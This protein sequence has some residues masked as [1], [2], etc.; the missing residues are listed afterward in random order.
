MKKYLVWSIEHG[1]WWGWNHS[2]YTTKREK[3][4]RYTLEDA[5]TNLS[6]GQSRPRHARRG[7]RP[8]IATEEFCVTIRTCRK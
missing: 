8:R 2:G 3:A 6:G 4:G 7:H 1:K 5:A